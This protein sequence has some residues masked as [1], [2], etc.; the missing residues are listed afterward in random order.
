MPP[1]RESGA[2]QVERNER[3]QWFS[4]HTPQQL[5]FLAAQVSGNAMADYA[6]GGG[7]FGAMSADIDPGQER[8]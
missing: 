4:Q 3:Q 1:R 6:L 7:V 8:A 2:A 5:V